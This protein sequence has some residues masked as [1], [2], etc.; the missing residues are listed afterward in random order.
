MPR[1]FRSSRWV[2][3]WL[4]V[5]GLLAFTGV[6]AEESQRRPNFLLILADDVGQEVLGSYG[7]TSYATPNLDRLAASG[8]RFEHTYAMAVCHPTRVALLS[9]RYPFRLGQPKWGTYPEREESRSLASRLREAGYTTA[10][11]GKWQLALLRKDPDHARRLG[12][13]HSCLFGWH[14]GARYHDPHIRENGKLR[15]VIEGGYGPRIYTDFLI[16]FL[17]E[18][19]DR[20]CF[21]F[22]SMALCH[23]VTDDLKQPV[24]YPPGLDRYMNYGEMVAEMD[25][26]VGELLEALEELDLERETV[27]IFLGDNGTAARSILRA[28]GKRY[29]REPVFSSR[30]EERI[31]GGK[32]SLTDTGT[33]VP[34]L[35]RWP[36]VVRPGQVIDDL[37]DVSDLYPTFLELAGRDPAGAGRIDGQSFVPRLVHGKPGP[38]EFV[39]A[40]HRGPSFVRDRRWKLYRDGRLFDVPADPLEKSPLSGEALSGEAVRARER[41]EAIYRRWDREGVAPAVSGKN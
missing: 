28:E 35:V 30:G 5:L 16:R 3:C 9:G 38:R 22:Y 32:G 25:L 17:R 23:D 1:T 14:E 13:D 2:P 8:M 36:G 41:L 24:R 26:R 34:F 19:R 21:A 40:E 12:F 31:P 27:V 33:R 39:F 37:V 11:A 4:F 6:Q 10:V 15:G 7:G 29:V 20:P 18:N